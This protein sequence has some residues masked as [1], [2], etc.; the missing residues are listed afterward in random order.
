MTPLAVARSVNNL[1]GPVPGFSDAEVSRESE[2]NGRINQELDPDV[3]INLPSM[4]SLLAGTRMAGTLSA[5]FPH[6]M[7]CAGLTRTTGTIAGEAVKAWAVSSPH[8]A[9]Y[10][11]ACIAFLNASRV[12]VM[13][14]RSLR[15]SA[16]KKVL[17]DK[18]AAGIETDTRLILGEIQAHPE[19]LEQKLRS[20]RI[21]RLLDQTM[22]A[23]AL[24]ACN[25]GAVALNFSKGIQDGSH[26]TRDTWAQLLTLLTVRNF[27][28]ATS[29]D[30]MQSF[31][32]ISKGGAAW[33]T[34]HQLTP[35][36][37]VYGVMQGTIAGGPGMDYGTAWIK[38]VKDPILRKLLGFSMASMINAIPEVWDTFAY[39]ELLGRLKAKRSL[40]PEMELT[41]FKMGSPN[42]N[43][44]ADKFWNQSVTREGLLDML[45]MVIISF[46]M[47]IAAR[48]PTLAQPDPGSDVNLKRSVATG[49]F[50]I[51]AFALVY[52]SIVRVWQSF[53][54]VR[55]VPSDS[56]EPRSIVGTGSRLDVDH[57]GSSAGG[58]GRTNSHA[59]GPDST[60]ESG[61]PPQGP[62]R[63][64]TPTEITSPST[65]Q[66]VAVLAPAAQSSDD[67][68]SV[69]LHSESDATSEDL[70]AS[71]QSASQAL[72]TTLMPVADLT[73]ADNSGLTPVS[74]THVSFSNRLTINGGEEAARV[75][76]AAVTHTKMANVDEAPQRGPAVDLPTAIAPIAEMN[77]TAPQGMAAQSSVAAQRPE[78]IIESTPD[79]PSMDDAEWRLIPTRD[80]WRPAVDEA[81]PD[82][83]RSM[84]EN[85][86]REARITSEPADAAPLAATS[87]T[88]GNSPKAGRS[89]LAA[90]EGITVAAPRVDI[91]ST[92][93]PSSSGPLRVEE[94]PRP[95]AAP[96]S[97]ERARP[98]NDG[99]I[100]NSK[101]PRILKGQQPEKTFQQRLKGFIALG[102]TRPN[103]NAANLP[104]SLQ[105]AA[106]SSGATPAPGNGQPSD[107]SGRE[108]SKKSL[109][110][111]IKGMFDG[112][113][114]RDLLKRDEFRGS[115]GKGRTTGSDPSGEKS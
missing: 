65:G 87:P 34:S 96:L 60:T 7:V 72:T 9:G 64:G 103:L 90:N 10:I 15:A 17:A 107:Q 2:R 71:T 61:T 99:T 80:P 83:T 44:M 86:S 6:Q 1:I 35:L 12:T 77:E 54:A 85:T 53:A 92:G 29:R 48:W 67:G 32:S 75:E 79:R 63:G 5:Y 111:R 19:A 91:T 59:R 98:R 21:R 46:D 23:G 102:R 56:Q 78:N 94:E 104:P 43:V 28:Y 109:R 27:I 51:A 40:N 55:N 113:R 41:R 73:D 66:P 58:A 62:N 24:L 105:P 47:L 89:G 81:A 82:G 26:P 4:T 97:V 68:R 57:P 115:P 93:T 106:D 100:Y 95:R 13:T 52:A 50:T 88:M 38:G 84:L 112:L 31:F 33:P 69:E 25:F 45:A 42:I 18:A 110:N 74:G 101:N 49:A 14:V 20:A 8:A 22:F 39:E 30:A 36:A 70:H 3:P 37:I 16:A 114:N 11:L 108:G 76:T